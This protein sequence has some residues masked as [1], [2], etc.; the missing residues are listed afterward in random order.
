MRDGKSKNQRAQ[1]KLVQWCTSVIPT[2]QKQ[3]KEDHEFKAS[4]G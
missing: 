3:R 1:K 2:L 4:L